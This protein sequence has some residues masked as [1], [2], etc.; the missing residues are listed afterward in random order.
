MGLFEFFFGKSEAIWTLD[1]YI[2]AICSVFRD[3]HPNREEAGRKIRK[4]GEE[5]LET[6]GLIGINHAW[7]AVILSSDREELSIII[8]KEWKDIPGWNA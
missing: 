6:Y 8:R 5:I 7:R 1:V 2:E 3:D 4:W